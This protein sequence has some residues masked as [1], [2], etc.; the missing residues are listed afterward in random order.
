MAI[1][2]LFNWK[3]QPRHGIVSRPVAHGAGP[4]QLFRGAHVQHGNLVNAR[5]RN[6]C[7]WKK[8]CT[9]RMVESWNP[10]NN[11]W[12]IW[13]V[14]HLSTGVGFLPSTPIYPSEKWRKLPFQANWPFLSLPSLALQVM[15]YLSKEITK[16]SRFQSSWKRAEMEV[17]YGASA[18][19]QARTH[20]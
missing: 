2:A 4:V 9:Q 6:Y 8:C 15:Y 5:Y 16:V 17:L 7:G 13:G 19:P 1:Y 3:L 10:I 11:L 18:W 20:T 14:Y 12:K